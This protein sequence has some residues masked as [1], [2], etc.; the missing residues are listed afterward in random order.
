MRM[1]D[2]FLRNIGPITEGEQAKLGQSR[3]FIAG[4]G[5]IGGFLL[6]YM[7][8]V[9]VGHII[10]ADSDRFE[11]SNLNRQLLAD[12]ETIGQG[13]AACAA[14]RAHKIWPQ[15]D[16]SGIDVYLDEKSLPPLIE[17]CDLV[18]DAFDNVQSRKAL[19]HAC[20]AAGKVLA[21]SSVSGWLAQAALVF[22]GK[23]LYDF[24][25]PKGQ[26]G[27]L[28]GVLS[29]APASAAAMQASLAVQYLCGRPDIKETLHIFNLQT[30][31]IDK[32]QF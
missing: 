5:G 24:I 27:P 16:V 28:P 18:M 2:R 12:C 21:H 10:C 11:E 3:I 25:Y 26:A 31:Q 7:I 23:R 4:C 20:A 8:R 17:N 32:I 9:G 14:A 22:P 6:E 19:F 13:K 30:L 15:A 1:N 29:F